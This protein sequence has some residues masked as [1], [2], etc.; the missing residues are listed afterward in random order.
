[1]IKATIYH[2]GEGATVGFKIKNHG[3]PIVCAAVSMLVINTVNSIEKLT[4]LT[5]LDFD[6]QWDNAGGHL[7]FMLNSPGLRSS[8]AGLLLDALVLGLDSIKGQYPTEISI[9]ATP[10]K[11]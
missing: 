7:Q 11:R 5:K 1:M 4:P 6:C 3:E 9:I 2:D 10:S 8:G